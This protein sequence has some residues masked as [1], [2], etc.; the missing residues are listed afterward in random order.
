MAR[1][2]FAWLI[3][4][5]VGAF[6]LVYVA[7]EVISLVLTAG[8]AVIVHNQIMPDSVEQEIMFEPAVRYLRLIEQIWALG[9]HILLTA[10]C[11]YYC[12]YRGAWLHK[13]LISRLPETEQS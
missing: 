12:F 9:I 10:L 5:A 11:S 6:F 2:E 4:R 1:D 7:L 8:Q 13:L 3:V